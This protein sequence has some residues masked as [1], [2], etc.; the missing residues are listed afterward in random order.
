LGLHYLQVLRAAKIRS[1]VETDLTI[2]AMNKT[3]PGASRSALSALP[4]FTIDR[5]RLFALIDAN[6][7]GAIWLHG[8]P[9]AGKT[10]LARSYARHVNTVPLFVNTTR[11]AVTLAGLINALSASYAHSGLTQTALP[12]MEANSSARADAFAEHFFDALADAAGGRAV[13]I[14]D[15]LHR[16]S[17][18]EVFAAV[19]AGIMQ[20]AGRLMIIVSSQHLPDATFAEP[21]ARGQLTIIGRPQLAL[22]EEEATA[23]AGKLSGNKETAVR[24]LAATGGWAAGLMLGLQYAGA[25]NVP[26][27][28][29]HEP[30]TALLARYAS[31]SMSPEALRA[32]AALRHLPAIPDAALDAHTDGP[33]VREALSRL[34][35]RGLFVEFE[36]AADERAWRLHDLLKEALRTRE[37]AAADFPAWAKALANTRHPLAAARLAITGGEFAAALRDCAEHAEHIATHHPNQLIELANE[38]NQRGL[39]HPNLSYWAARAAVR[40]DRAAADAWADS[41]YTQACAT[42]D[43]PLALAIVALMLIERADEFSDTAGY[44][45]WG[46]RLG[47]LEPHLQNLSPK[48]RFTL[49]TAQAALFQLRG[50]PD[51]QNIEQLMMAVHEETAHS[52]DA[53]LEGARLCLS[54]LMSR[55]EMA[56]ACEF[57]Q[58]TGSSDLLQNVK[59]NSLARWLYLEGFAHFNSLEL[60]KAREVFEQARIF[61]EQTGEPSLAAICAISLMRTYLELGDVE[62]AYKRGLALQPSLSACSP[63]AQVHGNIILGRIF[64]RKEAFLLARE[65]LDRAVEAMKWGNVAVSRAPVWFMER[66]QCHVALREFGQAIKLADQ[67]SDLYSGDEA[68]YGRTVAELVRALQWNA[69]NDSRVYSALER[70]FSYAQQLGFKVFFRSLPKHASELCGIALER[71]VSIPFVRDVIRTRN[72]AAPENVPEQWPWKVWI[73]LL[74]GFQIVLDG[75]VLQLSG[76]VAAKP[77]ELIKL[78]ASSRK[79]SLQQDAVCASLWPDTCINELGAARKNLESTVSRARKLIGDEVI[80]VADGRVFFDISATGSD[81]QTLSYVC[82]RLIALPKTMSPDL[83]LSFHV[84]RLQEA[85]RGEFL[86]GEDTAAWIEATRLQVRS[87][88]VRAASH[89]SMVLSLGQRNAEVIGLL[90]Q[91]ISREPLAEE[92][93]GQLMKAYMIEGRR[94]EAMHTYRRCKQFLSIVLGV[95]PSPQ[96]E[97]IKTELLL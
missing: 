58:R 59:S 52:P 6:A 78:L 48:D 45:R 21:L 88:F 32:L 81:I 12:V 3:V 20:C 25:S 80:R 96:T 24:L 61:A 93:Y 94:A 66:I 84:N 22:D 27:D 77:L 51:P 29:A 43:W 37:A 36:Q 53:W 26:T 73:Q 87:S 85:Y 71:K 46:E 54:S 9:G 50:K 8:P 7:H 75:E 2:K 47:E 1:I 95:S 15:D 74:G 16:A 76:K 64:L 92:L 13:V 11:E 90:E 49:L 82:N 14:L 56:R 62:A 41:A 69:E 57:A 31:L 86:P 97:Q 4:S 79:M 17:S 30:T 65:S 60:H 55:T 10:T 70:G 91:A 19:A 34:A 67:Y 5:P 42:K 44:E 23:L 68:L 72:L 39:Q 28:A 18:P 83:D 40:T 33:A 35:A 89:L 38:L 63:L